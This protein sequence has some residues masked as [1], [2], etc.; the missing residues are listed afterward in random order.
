MKV[1][2][3]Q[4]S[5]WS[6]KGVECYGIYV[7]SCGCPDTEF[8]NSIIKD[9]LGDGTLNREVAFAD[10]NTLCLL[11]NNDLKEIYCKLSLRK[12]FEL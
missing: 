8:K 9:W 11:E 10:Y 5:Y 4:Y 7:H 3:Y 12:L 1:A 2:I 6:L